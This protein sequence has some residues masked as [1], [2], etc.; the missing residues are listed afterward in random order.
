MNDKRI[1]IVS[2]HYGSGKT[3]IALS[4][5]LEL[6]ERHDKVA[7]A[8]IDIVNPYFRSKDS[9]DLLAKKGIRLICSSYANT[10][11]DIPAL[12]QDIYAITD[13]KSMY[14]VLD[15]GGDERGALAL[16]RIAPAIRE[17]GN[18]EMLY[19]INRFRP[20][21]ADIDGALEVMREIEAACGL[22]FTGV[23][24]NSNLG[25]ETTADGVLSS[26]PFAKE[27][28][29]VAGI[30]YLYTT[31]HDTLLGELTDKG[32]EFRP[33]SLQKHM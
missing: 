23:V 28:A 17:E 20:L 32:G 16:G 9:E 19:V 2:G 31:V 10:N 8:D 7:I 22:R 30:P 13:D 6:K 24:N 11:V 33:I 1:T 5:V 4:L 26:V 27:V 15:V 3:N 21:T 29:K 12:P 14:C 25:I 18:Y